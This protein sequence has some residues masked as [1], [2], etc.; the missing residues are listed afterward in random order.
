MLIVP[1]AVLEKVTLS[2]S[3]KA[4]VEVF[5]QFAAVVASQSPPEAKFQVKLEEVWSILRS[6]NPAVS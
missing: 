2:P 3:M 5:N 1:P 4:W 6:T